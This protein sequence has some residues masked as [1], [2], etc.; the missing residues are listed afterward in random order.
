MARA[1]GK[2]KSTATSGTKPSGR[3]PKMPRIARI[4]QRLGRRIRGA[5]G[6]E[7]GADFLAETDQPWMR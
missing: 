7:C 4:I 1:T 5:E 3:R 2:T 6:I